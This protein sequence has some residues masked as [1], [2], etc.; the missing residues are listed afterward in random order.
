MG[1]DIVEIIL[2]TEDK[3]KVSIADAEASKIST[4]GQLHQLILSKIEPSFF[5]DQQVWDELCSILYEQVR[6]R[7]EKIF[8]ESRFVEDLGIE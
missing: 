8:P 5:T 6:I 7:K 1:L 3:F 2:A 4:V